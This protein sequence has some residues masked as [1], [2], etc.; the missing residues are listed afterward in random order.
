MD[1]TAAIPLASVFAT[2][3]DR[4]TVLDMA[5]RSEATER[6]REVHPADFVRAM[7][8][9]ASG[10]EKR[11]I[12]SCRRRYGR[13]SR[14]EPEESTFYGH[15]NKGMVRLIEQ[16]L[17]KAMTRAPDSSR[18]LLSRLLDRAGLADMLALDAS[19]F[20]LP[21][22]AK[23]LYPSTDDSHGGVKL[24]TL[25]SVLSP[26]IKKV[27]V[28]DARQH[29]RKV[30]KLPR[31]L[32]RL[33]ILM[34]RGYCDRKLFAQIE[35][36]R[37]FFLTRLKKSHRPVIKRIR[38]GL[39]QKSLGQPFSNE[40]PF[41]GEVDLDAT[42]KMPDGP[43]RE[44]RVVRL[45]V[46]SQAV[47][48]KEVPVELLFVTN[49]S[50]KQFTVGQL[51]TLYR[52]RWEVERLFAVCK[53]VGRLDHLRSGNQNVVEAFVYA[54]LLAVVL[55]LLVCSWMR[56]RRPSCEP[57]AWRVTTLV[58]EW[59]PELARTAG[60]HSFWMTFADFERVLWREGV[61]PNPGRPY[62]ATQYT[63]ELG[64]QEAYR[65]ATH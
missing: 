18:P 20:S 13:I 40:L 35:D 7:I 25:M 8:E 65:C 29:D 4:K 38:C 23:E 24:T 22:W 58:L 53:G 50:P 11:T 45:V 39:D 61:N 51:A 55:G 54:T 64:W 9:C 49:L 48:G 15:F 41:E 33:L 10:D 47:K 60:H 44:F 28:T 2:L 36:R 21:S 14:F 52:F 59:L 26:T 32:H 5:R 27:I 1:T 57:S 62:T 43:E 63:F 19:R 16:L 46:G 3:F 12:A 31:W 34:D 56:Q 42:F 17:R 30:V 6:L 37:G